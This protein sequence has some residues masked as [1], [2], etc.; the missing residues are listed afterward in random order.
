[1]DKRIRKASFFEASYYKLKKKL[2]ELLLQSFLITLGVIIA[3]AIGNWDEDRK[4]DREVTAILDNIKSEALNNAVVVEEWKDY[5]ESLKLGI[6]SVF[7]GQ[8]PIASVAT[9]EGII[10][11]NLGRAAKPLGL[12]QETAWTTAQTTNLVQYFEYRIIYQLTDMYN[13][14]TTVI[15]KEHNALNSL[16]LDRESFSTEKARTNLRMIRRHILELEANHEK[17]LTT[18]NKIFQELDQ[19]L[20]KLK[21]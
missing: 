18:Y 9:D 21:N 8:K 11:E 20:A 16:F 10:V 14:Q 12:L 7:N 19:S 5:L 17:I 15:Q 2:P 3:L 13:Y 4:R 6:D 1:M